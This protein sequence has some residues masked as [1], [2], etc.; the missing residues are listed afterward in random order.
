MLHHDIT[1]PPD[2]TVL[3]E[4]GPGPFVTRALLERPDGTRVEWTSRRHRK[5]LGTRPLAADGTTRSH[6]RRHATARSWCIGALFMI[7]SFCFAI[8]SVPWF[9]DRVSTA[10]DAWTFFVGSVFFTSA[11]Y[12]QFHEAIN[13]PAG[14]DGTH[15]ARHGL[16]RLLAWTPR[17]IDYWATL[18]Q[19]VGT[20]FFNV[21]TFAATRGDLSLQQARRLIWA[22]DVFGSICFLVASWFAY[23]EVCP[24]LWCARADRSVGWWIAALN[25]L[26]S[27]AFGVAA[28]ASRILT[29]TSEVANLS[30]VN[31]GTFLGA[32]GFFVGAALLPV[33]STRAPAPGDA[34]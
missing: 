21:T 1:V 5:R 30:L 29:S 7:G 12:L 10:T 4:S 26:G 27:I 14:P 13:A 8:G 23:L 17:R 6:P 15:S 33:E 3:D 18:V 32:V 24:R 19:L 20:V 28:V 22:P 25:L 16:R 11:S 2:W 9:F 34:G 31:L